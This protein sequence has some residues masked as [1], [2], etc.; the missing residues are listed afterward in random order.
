[1]R[2]MAKERPYYADV[3]IPVGFEFIAEA[4]EDSMTGRRRLYARHVYE[5]RADL[6][7][8]L[9]FYK[10]YMPKPASTA[11]FIAQVDRQVQ[12]KGWSEKGDP[13][14]IVSGEPIGQVGR[15]NK[16]SIHYVGDAS[17]I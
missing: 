13:I 5:G 8:V 16:L 17:G 4:S 2:M 15:T 7:S 12:E 1:M 14:I 10:D 3:P 9:N 11:E 6:F